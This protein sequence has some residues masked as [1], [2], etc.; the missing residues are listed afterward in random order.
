MRQLILDLQPQT[1][2]GFDNF[3]P[4]ENRSVLD[5]LF[6]WLP[7]ENEELLFFLWGE[8]GSGKTHLLKASALP[9]CDAAVDPGLHGIDRKLQRYA[10][11]HVDKL[12]E[13]GQVA[14][15]NLF[16]RFRHE[17]G[18]LLVAARN[19]PAKM[20]MREDLRTRLANGLTYRVSPLTDH[21]KK[22]VLLADAQ[23]RKL[24]LSDEMVDYLLLRAP[25]DMRSLTALLEAIDRYS[26]EHKR[27]ITQP[28]LR[29]ILHD[30]PF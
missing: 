29:E 6:N 26:L 9:Y 8:E 16:N 22:A 4:G 13:Q 2:P 27:V 10:V 17:K 19:A 11:D 23:A 18:K 5:G 3:V 1:P 15:F 28:L 20:V 30:F 24:P 7:P 21:E 25:R 14:L 12:D